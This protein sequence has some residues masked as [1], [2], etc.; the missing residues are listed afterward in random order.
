MKING[1][2]FLH[3]LQAITAENG[4][5]GI[6]FDYSDRRCNVEAVLNF[7]FTNKMNYDLNKFLSESRWSVGVSP[8][9]PCPPSD[10]CTDCH[11]TVVH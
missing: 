10:W 3:L 8:A 4:D 5:L 9:L 1:V 2:L 7:M 6:V 11:L